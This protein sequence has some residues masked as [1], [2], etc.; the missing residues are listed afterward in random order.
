MS[1]NY[2]AHPELRALLRLQE[3][4]LN[5]SRLA[6]IGELTGGIAHE[7]NQP[8]CAVAN[9][10]QACDRLLAQPNPDILCVREALRS[11]ASQA[12]RAGEVIRRLR[13]LASPKGRVQEPTDVHLLL[14]GLR[15]L[16]QAE[17]KHHQAHYRLEAGAHLPE[18]YIDR[19]QVQQLLLNLVRNAAEALEEVPT[20][21][22]SITVRTAINA[23]GEV[24]ICVLDSG[25]GVADAIAPH[26]FTPFCS[27]KRLGTGLGL[28]ISR[29]LAH[30][31]SG[32]LQYRPNPPN[33][34]CFALTLPAAPAATDCSGE[35]ASIPAAST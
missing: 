29:T 2:P 10:A 9:Y 1:V 32:T 6:T 3:Q 22:R 17:A 5:G 11:I 34:A 13:G 14:R 35:P 23:H 18:V 31:N 33:G 21:S 8:L 4:L 19:V 25:L 20:A 28:A 15:D 12:L 7:L 30:A 16:I 24:E 27:S 26:L